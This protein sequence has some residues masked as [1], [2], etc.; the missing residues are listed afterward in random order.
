MIDKIALSALSNC[1]YPGY[2]RTINGTDA[3]TSRII[4][5]KIVFRWIVYLVIANSSVAPSNR[6]AKDKSDS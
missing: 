6:L 3:K 2:N 4:P 5:D 1:A